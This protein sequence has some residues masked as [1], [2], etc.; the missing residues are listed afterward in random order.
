MPRKVNAREHTTA[1]QLESV[2]CSWI[3]SVRPDG[4]GLVIIWA[5]RS[6]R[7]DAKG[8]MKELGCHLPSANAMTGTD[9][10]TIRRRPMRSIATSATRV[11]RKLVIAI[12][13]EVKMGEVN[14]IR[15]NTVA[16]KYIRQ[17]CTISAAC[18]Y[19]KDRRS[20][21]RNRT[22]VAG[23][24]IS[25]QWSR[26]AYCPQPGKAH[27]KPEKTKMSTMMNVDDPEFGGIPCR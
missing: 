7:K 15:E 27:D 2:F 20:Y 26:P 16:E 14:P 21:T 19:N 17:F 6:R 1:Q 12:E 23:F 18:H 22:I 9:H 5:I 4:P 13:S 24:A 10:R 8:D 11:N 25:M 3:P